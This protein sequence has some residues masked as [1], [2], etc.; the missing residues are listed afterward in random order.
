MTMVASHSMRGRLLALLL[1]V[2]AVAWAAVAAL[3]YSDARREIDALL[4]AHLAQA[5][6]LLIAQSGHELEEIDLEDAYQDSPYSQAVA[7][8]VWEHGRRLALKSVNA[9]SHRLSNADSGFSEEMAGPIHWRV[10]SGWDPGHEVLV[11][12]A[13]D[14]GS[15]ERIARRISLNTLAPLLIVLPLLGLA[16]WWVVGRGVRPLRLLAT[17]LAARGP[18][19]LAPLAPRPMPD[20][21]AGVAS[22]LDRLFTRIRES[23]ESERR[24]TSHAA[25]E[26]RTPVAAIRAQAEVARTTADSA[27]RI[28][29][30]DHVIE[31]CDRAARLVEQLLLLA[32]ADEAKIES[33]AKPCRLDALAQSVLAELVPAALRQDTVL[34]LEAAGAMTA[35]GEPALLDALLRNLVDNALRHGGAGGRVSVTVT[36]D[37]RE[38]VVRVE[39]AGPGVPDAEIGRLG[40]RFYRAAGARGT[41]SGLGLSI[42]ARIVE[43]HRGTLRF[44]RAASGQGFT[45]EVRLPAPEPE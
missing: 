15:R 41:G 33:N 24:F 4:D 39:D 36:R 29:A 14:H 43:L 6:R 44:A 20:E 11:Q 8:Q 42:V 21:V 19:D 7:F 34:S 22:R 40:Q 5:A 25:H 16:I 1:T 35:A 28:A 37:G 2:V 3:T 27:Q 31:A 38:V 18:Q 32:R 13:E 45:V 9:P 30:L 17:E 12:V 26:L 10:Y 23:L